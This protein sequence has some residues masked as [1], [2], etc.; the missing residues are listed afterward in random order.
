MDR[1]P[2]GSV[3]IPLLGGFLHPTVKKKYLKIHGAEIY[4]P[5]ITTMYLANSTSQPFF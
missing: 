1:N 3:T 4:M 2:H 5:A